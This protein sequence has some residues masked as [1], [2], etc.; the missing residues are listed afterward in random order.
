M[1]LGMQVGLGPGHIVLDGGPSFPSQKGHSP[2]FFAHIFCGQ[3]AGW[4]KMLLGMEVGLA[5]V[6]DGD[7]APHPQ[8]G[9]SAP[10]FSPISIVV[11]RLDASRCQLVW[12]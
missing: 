9:G 6:L 5:T 11:K 2:Q 1:K 8:K 10:Q 12:R 7:P 3:I 4:I